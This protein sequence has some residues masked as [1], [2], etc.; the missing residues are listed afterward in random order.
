VTKITCDS[1]GKLLRDDANKIAKE[2][3]YFRYAEL[4]WVKPSGKDTKDKSR[5]KI[6]MKFK[7]PEPGKRKQYLH[8]CN[9]E[10]LKNLFKIERANKFI[11]KC[12]R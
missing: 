9:A 4:G 8:F 7:S 12:K 5:W 2:H 3:I 6:L 10:C 11:E 1:C